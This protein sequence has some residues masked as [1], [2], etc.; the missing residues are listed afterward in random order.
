ME[1]DMYGRFKSSRRGEPKWIGVAMAVGWVAGIWLL[2]GWESAVMLAV[3]LALIFALCV[4][5]SRRDK[6]D[7]G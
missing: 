6:R 2:M 7:E 5:L 4:W 3:V 1:R